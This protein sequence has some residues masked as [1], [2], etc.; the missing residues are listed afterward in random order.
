VILPSE[1]LG[2]LRVKE[3]STLQLLPNASG[4][5][6]LTAEDEEFEEQMRAARALMVRYR[7]TLREL[8][9]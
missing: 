9:K 3:G 6:R 8:D 7:E 2:T 1:V 4:G 5:Y